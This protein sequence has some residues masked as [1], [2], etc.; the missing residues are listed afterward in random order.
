[1]TELA[2]R[3]TTVSPFFDNSAL[4]SKDQADASPPESPSCSSAVNQVVTRLQRY[5]E[6][7]VEKI[8]D[9]V[10]QSGASIAAFSENIRWYN[11][12]IR[13]EDA[14]VSLPHDL[15]ISVFGI[16]FNL[17]SRLGVSLKPPVAGPG[18]EL[19][20]QFVWESQDQYLELDVGPQYQF[21]WFYKNLTTGEMAGTDED[22]VFEPPEELLQKLVTIA[23]GK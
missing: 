11:Y 9:A 17:E 19:G 1:M 6:G 8:Q 22:P 12:L 13:L 14:P 20:F 4:L 7:V 23:S 5:S 21:E 10:F 2:V 18:G 3:Y 15:A 16:W